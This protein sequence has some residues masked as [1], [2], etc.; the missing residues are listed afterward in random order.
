MRYWVGIDVGKVFHWICVLDEEGEVVLSERVGASEEELDAVLSRT[1]E[2]LGGERVVAIDLLGGP[3]TSLEAALLGRGERVFYVP[4]R[5]V[6]RVRDAYRGEAKS[7]PRD[8]FVIA[9]QLR[10]RYR[11]VQE[12]LPKSEL[13]AELKVLVSHRRDLGYWTRPGA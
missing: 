13:L 1:A 2:L 3:A 7:D 12:V 5:T 9:D 8:A 6:D 10:L 11:S 4:G